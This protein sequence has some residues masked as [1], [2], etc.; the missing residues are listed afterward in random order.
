MTIMGIPGREE[1]PKPIAGPN[2]NFNKTACSSRGSR[3]DM[4]K[5]AKR[6]KVMEHLGYHI[7]KKHSES[8]P[9]PTM[10]ASK[11]LPRGGMN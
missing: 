11:T 3:A 9:V 4:P 1:V 5:V 10:T 2:K 6:D 7:A 8:T